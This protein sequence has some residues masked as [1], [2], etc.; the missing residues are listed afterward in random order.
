MLLSANQTKSNANS[1]LYFQLIFYGFTI[2]E[3]ICRM[4]LQATFCT[5]VW[6][7]VNNKSN[8]YLHHINKT[9]KISECAD[10][11]QITPTPIDRS[12]VN[13]IGSNL[14]GLSGL[15]GAAGMA[16]LVGLLVGSEQQTTTSPTETTTGAV[17]TTSVTTT[18]TSSTSTTASTVSTTTTCPLGSM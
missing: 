2:V 17:T 4:W 13:H 16:G 12:R 3:V 5:Y 15:G 10:L 7:N 18:I 11:R 8:K 14:A 6:E 9:T 1:I